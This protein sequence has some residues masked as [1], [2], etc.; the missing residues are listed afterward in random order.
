MLH[1]SE[2]KAMDGKEVEKALATLSPEELNQLQ[3]NWEFWARPNQLAP[4]G[5]WKVWLLNCG[6]GFGKT[7]MLE[8]I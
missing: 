6:R 3:Y 4:E 5:A 8:F 2:L 1:S 7:R